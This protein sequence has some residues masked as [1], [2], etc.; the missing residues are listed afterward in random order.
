[1]NKKTKIQWLLISLASII[2]VF[3]LAAPV[4]LIFYHAF[5]KGIAAFF[6]NLSSYDIPHAIWLTLLIAIITIPINL[7]FGS[8]FAWL[9]T[10]FQFR[11]RAF[12]ITLLDIPFAVSPVIAGLLYLLLYG[13]N[14]LIGGWLSNYDIQIVF[15]WPAMILVTI[16]VTSPFV[17]RELIP[18]MQQN[19]SAEEEAAITL[20]ANIW[21][22]WRKV[23]LP[24]ILWPLIYG[25]ALTNARAIGEYGGVSMVS[26]KIA[27][28]TQTL[29]IA[30]DELYQSNLTASAAF[31]CATILAL[32]ALSTLFIKTYVASKEHQ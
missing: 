15:A 20:G 12:L 2:A 25:V 10:R 6:Q 22:L 11:G 16:F 26:S 4:I 5:E 30:V 7:I 8:A 1:M 24:N 28:E 13:S 27:G 31:A 14:S 32:I 29:P 17:A 23:T 9:V 18:F 3:F 21:Q 19:G